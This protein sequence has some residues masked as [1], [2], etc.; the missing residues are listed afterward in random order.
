MND[1]SLSELLAELDAE[2]GRLAGLNAGDAT[3]K[4]TGQPAS[5]DDGESG[6]SPPPP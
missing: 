4:Q 5:R 2:L 6:P 3:T 1:Q